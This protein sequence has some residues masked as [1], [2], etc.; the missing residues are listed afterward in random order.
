MA[1]CEDCGEELGDDDKNSMGHYR[2]RCLDCLGSDA[3]V[4]RHVDTCDDPDCMICDS[5]ANDPLAGR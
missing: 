1:T 2:D 5:H 4:K 3:P